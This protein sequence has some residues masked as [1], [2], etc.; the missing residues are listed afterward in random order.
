M[1]DIVFKLTPFKTI[2]FKAVFKPPSTI[3]NPFKTIWRRKCRLMSKLKKTDD[4]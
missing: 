1:V 4:R 3:L 2:T